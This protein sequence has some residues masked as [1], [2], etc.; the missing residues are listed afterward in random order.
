MFFTPALSEG[1]HW[2]LSYSK[3]SQVSRALLSILAGLSNG[4]FGRFRL[5]LRFL[6]PPNPLPS[7]GDRSKCTNYNWYHRYLPVLLLFFSSLARSK[8]L[9]LFSPDSRSVVRWDDGITII[10][11][12]IFIIIINI[13]LSLTAFTEVSRED[14]ISKFLCFLQQ[15]LSTVRL[16][17]QFEF[18][19]FFQ[20]ASPINKVALLFTH[21]REEV[22]RCYWFVPC[23]K[24]LAWREIHR[25]SSRKWIWFTNSKTITCARILII[26]IVNYFWSGV[27][28]RNWNASLPNT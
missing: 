11:I 6:T 17:N 23:P 24:V 5:V 10:I 28:I 21:S 18:K 15:F 13:L 4:V 12:I 7:L 26:L 19:L 14:E 3:S 8:Y 22:M 9:F 20:N 16:R 27:G 25:A 2:S 1:F